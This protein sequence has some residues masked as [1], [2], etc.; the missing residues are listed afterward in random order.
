MLDD[1]ARLGRH[2]KGFDTRFAPPP[3][4]RPGSARRPVRASVP[5]PREKKVGM[6]VE[7]LMGTERMAKRLGLLSG[8]APR[9][10]R[11]V[12]STDPGFGDWGEGETDK[13]LLSF[14]VC[15]YELKFSP[16]RFAR[17]IEEKGGLYVDRGK[18]S[19]RVLTNLNRHLSTSSPTGQ[20]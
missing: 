15:R 6:H 16:A 3:Q 5:V 20:S 14:Q 4:G 2:F 13:E 9:K 11:S 10:C 18:S 8:C 7:L 12:N 19:F 17:P 1:Y